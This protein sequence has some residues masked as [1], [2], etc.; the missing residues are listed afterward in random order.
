MGT[1]LGHAG[2]AITITS[3]TS[4]IAF[5]FASMVDFKAISYFCMVG[6]FGIIGVY[7]LQLTFFEI[8]V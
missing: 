7:M 2:Y 8:D 3:I 1:A 6:G 5:F 4:S